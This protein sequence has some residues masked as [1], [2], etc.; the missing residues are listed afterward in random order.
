M[1]THEGEFL[2]DSFD[3]ESIPG[4][5]EKLLRDKKQVYFSK[6]KAVKLVINHEWRR[7]RNKE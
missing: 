3:F 7:T 2:I 4:N 5:Q 1:E 6:S